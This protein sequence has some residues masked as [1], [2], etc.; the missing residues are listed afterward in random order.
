MLDESK[1]ILNEQGLP[2]VLDYLTTAEDVPEAID[3]LNKLAL[4][5][6]ND[7]KDIATAVS[8]FEKAITFGEAQADTAD[9]ADEHYAIESKLKAINYNLGANTWPGWGDDVELTPALTARGAKAAARNLELAIVLEKGDLPISRAHWLVGAH[10]LAAGNLAAARQCFEQAVEFGG[11]AG[12][13]GDEGLSQG[14][15]YLVRQLQCEDVAAE[16]E[17]LKEKLSAMEHGEFFVGQLDT[18]AA[19]FGDS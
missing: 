6:Y 12:E 16:M 3:A 13:A 4:S 15:V 5:F 19:I 9:D 14:Y 11:K 1:Q 10:H 17:M 8:I 2:A 18:A 7:H